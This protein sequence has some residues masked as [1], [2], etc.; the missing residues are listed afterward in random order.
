MTEMQPD[1]EID[2]E[3]DQPEPT[4]YSE[5]LRDVAE[6][7]PL[8]WPVDD[9]AP[10]EDGEPLVGLAEDQLKAHMVVGRMY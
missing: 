5:K 8:T 2:Q 1:Q 4:A 9:S 7:E 6:G 10:T 3:I